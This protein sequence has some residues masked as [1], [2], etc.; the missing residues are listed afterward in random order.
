MT[1]IVI[2]PSFESLEYRE[3]EEGINQALSTIDY[4]LS[5]LAGT[6]K[7]HSAL[8]DT[9][10]F[11]QNQTPDYP[12]LNFIGE[13]FENLNINLVAVRSNNGT[14]LYCQSYALDNS[15]LIETSANTKQALALDDVIWLFSSVEDK[16]FGLMLLDEEPVF[17][18]TAPIVNSRFEGPIAGGML[19]GKYVNAQELEQLQSIMYMNFSLGTIPD[20]SATENEAVASLLAGNPIVVKEQSPEVVCGY[21]IVED[22]H[23]EPLFVL[24][25]FQNRLAYQQSQFVMN[26]S[27]IFLAVLSVL[28]AIA[29]LIFLE[30]NVV[31]PMTKLASYVQETSFEKT[32]SDDLPRFASE[33]TALV[34]KAVKDSLTQRLDAMRDVSTMVAHDLRNPLTGIKGASY[35]LQNKYGAQLGEQGTALLET[36]ND[37]V[38]YSDKIVKD[39]LDYSTEIKL[40]KTQTDPKKLVDTILSRFSIPENIQVIN[41][42]Q[43]QPQFWVDTTKMQRVFSNLTKN[44]FD[45]MPNGGTLTITSKKTGN[46]AEISFSDTGI[47]MPKE[48]IDKLW[49]PFFTTKAK[50][51]GVGLSITKRILEAHNATIKV[52]STPNKGTTFTIH[53]PTTNP[54]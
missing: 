48:V 32:E 34:A 19:F 23:S 22:I 8:D 43:N 5:V 28:V 7:D 27:F 16:N 45:A 13:T 3:S 33:E 40:D 44:A 54:K 1:V 51:M 24:Q 30:R 6:V 10:A 2:E 42:T 47:G 11:V 4:R 50:G 12:D 52:H 15:S 14:L 29:S 49:V 53:L 18:A 9:Y 20:F 46:Y 37:C 36:I 25:V 17:V 35:L 38:E 39:L 31:E 21:T 41:K 26:T